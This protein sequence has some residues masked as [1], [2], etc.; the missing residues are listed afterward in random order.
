MAPDGP[1]GPPRKAII[2]AAGLGTRLR[3]ITGVIPKELFPVGRYPAIEWVLA[4]AVASGCTELAVVTRARKRILEEYL[5]PRISVLPEGCTVSFLDQPEPLGLGHAL[6]L[7]RDF[8]GR[9]PFAVLLPDDLCDARTPPLVQMGAAFQ[10][11]GGVVFAVVEEPRDHAGRYGRLSLQPVDGPVFRVE[12][13]GEREP[14]EGPG[15]ILV[16]MGRYLLAP[17]CLDYAAELLDGQRD[18]ELDD[19]VILRHMIR[20]G[21]PVHC[22]WIEGSRYDV[23]T[24][25]GYIEA[26]RRFGGEHPQ[27]PRP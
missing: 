8:C 24:P 12:A 25:D 6:L 27:W 14:A 15:S 22:V 26:W 1:T 7:A 19:G 2:P 16:G 9:D 5:T 17:P 23:S 3:P 13:V 20:L 11:L 18:G 10:A 21:E 4:E